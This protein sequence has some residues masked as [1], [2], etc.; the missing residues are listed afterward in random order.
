M[1]ILENN[2]IIHHPIG[3]FYLSYDLTSLLGQLELTEMY[4]SLGTVTLYQSTSLLL[5]RFPET[6]SLTAI[7]VAF[8]A[9]LLSSVSLLAANA[10][11]QPNVQIKVIIA[12]IVIMLFIDFL[13]ILLLTRTTNYLVFF[14]AK[15]D[16]KNPLCVSIKLSIY[17]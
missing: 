10:V 6:V 16:S 8:A 11:M 5:E 17:F 14:F 3:V 15:S 4:P 7:F 2:E 13:I 12:M 1:R 9:E